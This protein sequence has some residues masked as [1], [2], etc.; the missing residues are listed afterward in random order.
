MWKLS[1][2]ATT[3]LAI[4]ALQEEKTKDLRQGNN[5]AKI[6]LTFKS[7]VLRGAK[8]MSYRNLESVSPK[9]AASE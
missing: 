8:V 6:R 1:K 2:I 9:R 3:F 7:L 4:C 5:K